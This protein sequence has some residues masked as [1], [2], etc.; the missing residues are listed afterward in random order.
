MRTSFPQENEKSGS[1]DTILTQVLVES[2]PA[3]PGKNVKFPLRIKRRG[4]T[5]A[6]IYRPSEAYPNYRVVWTA[7]GKRIMKGFR[8]YGPARKHAD[9]LVKELAKHSQAT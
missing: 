6:V 9:D 4:H 8:Q 3:E 1:A 2:K 7:G 5:L